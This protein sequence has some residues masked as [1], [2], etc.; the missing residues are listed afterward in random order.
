MRQG[1]RLKLGVAPTRRNVFSVPA[2]LE[3]KRQILE[4][5]T[6]WDI[7]F[8]SIDAVNEEGL[9]V[10]RTDVPKVVDLFRRE[11]VDALFVPH[12][13]FG[14]EDS[15]ARLAR[16]LGKPTL[17]W[18]PRD[19]APDADGDRPLDVQCGLFATSKALRRLG[20]PF[21]YI[22]NS[23]LHTGSPNSAGYFNYFKPDR[24][25][26]CTATVYPEGFTLKNILLTT[27]HILNKFAIGAKTKYIPHNKHS[28][29]PA[30]EIH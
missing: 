15:T 25:S 2:A 18:G 28:R 14:S 27:T 23:A 12:A 4:K 10:E 8:V 30:F 29:I 1:R 5:L 3:Q 11:G 20:V 26:Q 21:S 24:Y 16:D 7:D 17:L 19:P 6:A 9:L 22:V 13:N